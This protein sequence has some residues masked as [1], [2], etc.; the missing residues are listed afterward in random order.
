MIHHLPYDMFRCTGELSDDPALVYRA[1]C[2]VCLRRLAPEHPTPG[3]TQW[4]ESQPLP[5]DNH[6]EAQEP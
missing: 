2:S 4:M 1:D 3:R 6:L 5:C